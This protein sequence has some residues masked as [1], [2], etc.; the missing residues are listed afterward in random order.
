[1]QIITAQFLHPGQ[2]AIPDFLTSTLWDVYLTG[3]ALTI[4]IMLESVS[5]LI[6]AVV[7]HNGGTITPFI[8]D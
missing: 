4:E 3:V 8:G 6:T 1:M 7:N 5:V 2:Q